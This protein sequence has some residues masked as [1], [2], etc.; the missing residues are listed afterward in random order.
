MAEEA[1]GRGGPRRPAPGT[2]AA[3]SP[4]PTPTSASCSRCRPVTNA[5]AREVTASVQHGQARQLIGT[6]GVPLVTAHGTAITDTDRRLAAG[7]T[8]VVAPPEL[9][10]TNPVLRLQVFT[11]Y[12]DR[13]YVDWG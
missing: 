2:S 10:V 3:T 8:G 11:R 9:R 6:D 7:E 1:E 4:P 13:T 12:R 5:E